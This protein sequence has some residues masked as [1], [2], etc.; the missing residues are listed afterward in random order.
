MF[1]ETAKVEEHND[2]VRDLSN[3]AVINTDRN[4]LALAKA[5]KMALDRKMQEEKEMKED[6]NNLK[7]EMGDIKNMLTQLLERT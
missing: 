2:L 7:S 4:A 5:K 6:I 3:G 1:K